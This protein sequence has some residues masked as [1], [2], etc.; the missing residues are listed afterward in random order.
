MLYLTCAAVSSVDLEEYG[1]SLAKD[2]VSE[3]CGTMSR[4]CALLGN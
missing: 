4:F 2:W 3:E 1:V